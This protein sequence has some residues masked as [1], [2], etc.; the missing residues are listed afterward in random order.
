MRPSSIMLD[1]AGI[2]D[3]AVYHVKKIFNTRKYEM[4]R[5]QRDEALDHIKYLKK[6]L[7]TPSLRGSAAESARIEIDKFLSRYDNRD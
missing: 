1:M 2:V 6:V 4:V 7:E 5:R 3:T